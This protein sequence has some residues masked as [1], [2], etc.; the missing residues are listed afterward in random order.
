MLL[1]ASH[2]DA[3]T[4]FRGVFRRRTGL[5]RN[6]KFITGVVI[7]PFSIQRDSVSREAGLLEGLGITPRMYQK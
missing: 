2:S 5:S 7:F 3:L 6:R 4:S 1:Q